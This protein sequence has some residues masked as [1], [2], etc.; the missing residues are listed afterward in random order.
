MHCCTSDQ[1][2]S[3]KLVALCNPRPHHTP[4]ENPVWQCSAVH[5]KY[6]RSVG[7]HQ[8]SLLCSG[9]QM[10][11]Y[12]IRPCLCYQDGANNTKQLNTSTLTYKGFRR[13][14]KVSSSCYRVWILLSLAG[15]LQGSLQISITDR[16]TSHAWATLERQIEDAAITLQPRTKP[17][18]PH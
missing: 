8:D 14:S 6:G 7:R 11:H 4:H 16:A 5:V 12:K 18:L 1:S 3:P 10:Y 13:L 17:K 9:L 2:L 15:T